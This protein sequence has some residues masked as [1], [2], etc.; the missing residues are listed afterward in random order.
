VAWF[1]AATMPVLRWLLVAMGVVVWGAL[2]KK[3][4]VS[5]ER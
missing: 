1:F 4:S 3:C 5:R 2:V